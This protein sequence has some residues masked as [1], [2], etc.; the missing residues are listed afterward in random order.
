VPVTLRAFLLPLAQ[1]LRE[2]GWCVD[3]LC[4]PDDGTGS[5]GSRRSASNIDSTALLERSFDTVHT[6]GW[7]R[8]MRSL[9]RYPALAR[10]LRRIV[11]AGNY[12]VIH[13]HT[14]IASLVARLALRRVRGLR[15]IYTAHG[16]HFYKGQRRRFAGWFFRK[17]EELCARFTDV[18]VVMN[19]EDERAA[20]VLVARAPRCRVV[21]IDGIGIDLGAY[22]P[23]ELTTL[24]EEELRAR[25]DIPKDSF[26]VACI[27]EMNENKR[28]GLLLDTAAVLCKRLPRVR[29]LFIGTGPLETELRR[30]TREEDLPVCFTGQIER[31]ELCALF[32]LTDLG[33]LASEREGLP[34]SLMEFIAAGI[35][36]AGTRTRGIIDEVRDERALA[37]GNAASLADVIARIEKYPNLAAEL[38]YNQ[39]VYAA[40][41][42]AQEVI[43]PQYV[44]LY[45]NAEC[46]RRH[47]SRK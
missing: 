2:R 16:F 9:L 23:S 33:L 13:T 6:I 25:Y 15:V 35:P 3:A 17:A 38:A 4:G 27:A 19:S 41:H 24:Q 5:T 22:T 1:E 20:Q 37:A 40:E 32:A 30:R 26:V 12:N 45:E 29:W 44:T 36:I 46:S 11:A 8:S 18:L 43:L 14:P 31:E 39:S 47:R 10:E 21:R 42:F 7:S 28:H 34:R